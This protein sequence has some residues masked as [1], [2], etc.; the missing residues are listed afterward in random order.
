VR[1]IVE[2][3]AALAGNIRHMSSDDAHRRDNALFRC[4]EETD[5]NL[6]CMFERG[7]FH[8]S[9]LLTEAPA[10][11]RC[12]MHYAIT[13]RPVLALDAHEAN[14]DVLLPKA[15]L[16]VDVFRNRLVERFLHIDRAT[17]V[18]GKCR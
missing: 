13:E 1:L 6:P 14:P 15:G 12:I 4:A 5:L 10:L 3:V 2:R 16:C 7:K 18:P 11:L 8:L 17:C 9:G